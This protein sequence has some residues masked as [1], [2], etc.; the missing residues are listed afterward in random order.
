MP[1]QRLIVCWGSVVTVLLGGVSDAAAQASRLEWSVSVVRGS[2]AFGVV[3]Q[4]TF[5]PVSALELEVMIRNDEDSSSFVRLEPGVFEAVSIRLI[6]ADTSVP[7]PVTARW[8]DAAMCTTNG[9]G[10]CPLSLGASLPPGGAMQALVILGSVDGEEFPN[11]DYRIAL[12]FGGARKYLRDLA[13]EE[14]RGNLPDRG[15][16]PLVVKAAETP[17]ERQEYYRIEGGVAQRRG[18]LGRALQLYQA[19]MTEFSDDP[20]GYAGVGTV[21]LELGRFDD[22][23]TT[24]QRALEILP[25]HLRRSAALPQRLATAFVGMGQEEKAAATLRQDHGG[26]SASVSRAMETARR[27]VTRIRAGR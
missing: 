27:E 4:T 24:L 18:D 6:T 23:A 11:G 1:F 10:P 25:P 12:D 3:G 2:S 22:A 15:S 5:S 7:I 17:A 19:W 9:I 13:N 14:W 21:M 20:S 8:A 26:D 16:V